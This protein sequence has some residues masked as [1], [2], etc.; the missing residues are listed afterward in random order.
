MDWGQYGGTK[1]TSIS[2]YLIDFVNFI[3][4]NQELNIPHA[5]VAI[6]ADFRKAFNRINHNII[7]TILSEMGVPGWL[8]KIV[9]GFLSDRELILR[10][11][12]K[13]SSRKSLPEGG[14][15]GTRLGL[16]LFIILINAAGYQHLEKHM[17][18]KITQK[19][20]KRKP[21]ENIHMKYVDDMTI[22]QAINLLECLIH[23]PD[24]NPPRP[25]EHHDHTE[26]L[27]PGNNYQLQEQLDNL[28]E[29]CRKNQMKINES[30]SKVM[31]FN[32]RRKYDGRPRLTIQGGEDYLEVVEQF[33]LLGVMV[34]TDMKWFDN[35]DYI[36]QKGYA[37]LWML[38]RLSNLGATESEMLDVY[39]KQVRSVLELAVPVWQA[40]LTQ[41]EVKQIERVQRTAFYIIL[42][43]N[44]KDYT[45][46][47][48]LLQCDRLAERRYK[49]CEN[50]VKKAVKN[51]QF[52][53]WFCLNDDPVP[54]FKTRSDKVSDRNLYH[55]VKTRT[56]RYANSPLPYL[57]DILN[58][59]MKK[60]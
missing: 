8:L 50:F 9:I 43:D 34:R 35:S 2:H 40:G 21:I 7:I 46:A 58:K 10:Y 44:Y 26:H 59:L 17:G 54:N 52:Q 30:K 29:Y 14:P 45:N 13:C 22:A 31:I 3:L 38:R 23:N 47:L 60:K 6:M 15:Q 32:S 37:R 36:C 53:N 5:V 39:Q 20:S 42:G 57:T 51:E 18:L 56:E 24:P 12:G 41:Q 16:F 19:L 48:D 25:F 55:P 1:G 28:V 49:L 4:F 33:K 27:L 11:K